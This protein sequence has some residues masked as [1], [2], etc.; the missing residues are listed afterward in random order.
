VLLVVRE[1]VTPKELATKSLAVLDKAF[2][3]G[4]V[5]NASTGSPYADYNE[6][7][8]SHA[9]GMHFTAAAME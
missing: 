1:G 7:D 5:F 9:A 3:V 4:L 8:Q 6:L 2:I